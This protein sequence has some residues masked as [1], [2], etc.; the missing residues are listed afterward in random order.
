MKSLHSRAIPQK[1][2]SQQSSPKRKIMASH[3][4]KLVQN[5][6]EENQSGKGFFAT[7]VQF[8]RE[9]ATTEKE[10][11]MQYTFCDC[12]ALQREYTFCDCSARN[13]Y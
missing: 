2:I 1:E 13:S 3:K 6:V 11:Q 5:H 10:L 4:S 7:V 8:Y 9:V 12:S